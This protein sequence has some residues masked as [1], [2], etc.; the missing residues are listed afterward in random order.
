MQGGYVNFKPMMSNHNMF[1]NTGSEK[2]KFGKEYNKII[3]KSE[4]KKIHKCC[5]FYGLVKLV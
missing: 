4:K 5:H 3:E 1:T 2:M